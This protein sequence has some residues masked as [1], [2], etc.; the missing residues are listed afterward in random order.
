MSYSNE[1]KYQ[2]EDCP[3][4][5]FIVHWKPE[6]GEIDSGW[7]K[8]ADLYYH[9]YNKEPISGSLLA[10]YSDDPP[11][12]SSWGIYMKGQNPFI[13]KAKELAI[14]RNLVS[15]D[16]LIYA[17]LVELNEKIDS[18]KYCLFK[19]KEFDKLDELWYIEDTI[20]NIRED[21]LK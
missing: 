21:I 4:C 17:K 16:V 15:R 10:R 7:G 2:H 8:D 14:E 19:H 18:I 12:Y 3:N 13:I 11:D 20:K 1:P 9:E 6:S 5:T